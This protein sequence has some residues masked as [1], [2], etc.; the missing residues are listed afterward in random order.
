MRSSQ[1]SGWRGSFTDVCKC[2]LA[3]S[4]IAINNLKILLV[5]DGDL[6]GLNKMTISKCENPHFYR[7]YIM[8]VR[9]ARYFKSDKATNCVKSYV[10]TCS[11]GN[12]FVLYQ[13]SRNM[14][15]RFFSE[16][17]TGTYYL[18]RTNTCITNCKCKPRQTFASPMAHTLLTS[19]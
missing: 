16:F 18:P 9:I 1:F 17:L 11:V 5:I 6:L 3:G 12:W 7:Y 13:M 15:R 2:H 4:G 8:K 14:N 10:T 19:F